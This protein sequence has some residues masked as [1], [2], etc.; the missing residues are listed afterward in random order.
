MVLD[1][2]RIVG[3]S[4]FHSQVI[5]HFQVEFDTPRNLLQKEGGI[6]KSLVDE[7]ADRVILYSMAK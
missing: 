1:S 3:S 2:G 5:E 7:S 4:K 6:L